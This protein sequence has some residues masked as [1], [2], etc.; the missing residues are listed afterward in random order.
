MFQLS[1]DVNGRGSCFISYLETEWA[2][3]RV[4]ITSVQ[5]NSV[6]YVVL[7]AFMFS[8]TLWKV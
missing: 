7:K 3:Q 4:T 8:I 1:K 6:F 5:Q 2:D